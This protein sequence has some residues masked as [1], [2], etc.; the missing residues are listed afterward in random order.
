MIIFRKPVFQKKGQIYIFKLKFF[1]VLLRFL[2]IK[3]GNYANK[4]YISYKYVMVI[5]CYLLTNY[6]L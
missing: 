3:N 2:I 5:F 4:D 1:F 6:L